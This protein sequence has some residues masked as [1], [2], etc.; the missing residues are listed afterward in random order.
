MTEHHDRHVAIV[1]YGFLVDPQ[2][3]ANW[4]GYNDVEILKVG[5]PVGRHVSSKN[6]ITWR[7]PM[8]N[9]D[10]W[11]SAASALIDRLGGMDRLKSVIHEIAPKAAWLRICL[12]SIG[13]PFQESNGLDRKIMAQLVDLGLDFDIAMFEYDGTRPTHGKKSSV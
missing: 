5:A 12:P 9:D 10:N 4:V 7:Y 8:F 6:R 1:F 2:E 3:V 11:D 13:S